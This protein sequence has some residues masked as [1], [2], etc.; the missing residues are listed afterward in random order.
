MLNH[1]YCTVIKQVQVFGVQ[2]KKGERN[3]CQLDAKI[4]TIYN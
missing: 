1:N 4:K 2:T 3:V